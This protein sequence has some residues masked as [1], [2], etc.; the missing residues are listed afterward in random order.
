MAQTPGFVRDM[1]GALR[2]AHIVI[3]R[4]GAGSVIETAAARR[5]AIFVPLAVAANDHQS[6]NARALSDHGGAWMLRE[7]EFKPGP[8]AELLAELI[9]E[10]EKLTEAAD[11]ARDLVALGAAA[12]LADLVAEHMKARSGENLSTT[13]DVS[14]SNDN[15]DSSNAYEN[16]Q[17]ESNSGSTKEQVAI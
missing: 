15:H 9:G 17:P 11:A 10:P 5:P 4:A 8:L 7:V 6:F 14:A 12:A 2:A 3:G 13:P 1:A 16:L